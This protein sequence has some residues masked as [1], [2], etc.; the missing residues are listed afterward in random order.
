M[1]SKLYRVVVSC[2][3]SVVIMSLFVACAPPAEQMTSFTIE[4]TDQLGR[5]ARLDRIPERIVSLAPSNTEIL[6]AL[7]LGD[8]VVAV[9]DYCDYPPEAQA[10]PKIGG[11]STPNIEKVVALSPDLIL[12]TSIHEKRIIPALEGK[13]L[14]IFTLDPKNLDE[15][16]ESI[17]LVGKVTGTSEE[18][19]Q[20]ITEMRN[21]IKAVT[22]K[23][24]NLPQIQRPRV[25]YITWHDPL[26]TPGS[27]TRHDEL[28]RMAGGTNIAR[29]LTGYAAI[30]LEAVI[31]ANP[32]VIIAGVGMGSGED[33]PFQYV[34]TEPRLRN[35][36]ARINNRIYS[37]DVDLAGRPGPR[38]I[39]ALEELAEFIHPELFS[40]D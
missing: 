4:V 1:K 21:R 7:G 31:E 26:K 36:D 32:Q 38:Q 15:V 16:L 20:L 17:V 8:K 5:T 39:D 9:T 24:D 27:G 19:S 29:D 18:A 35:V 2:L 14:N 40:K 34:K 30:S 6:F 28:I 23:T 13:G 25:F 33:L 37:M 22:D 11:F 12:A 10:K 3:V